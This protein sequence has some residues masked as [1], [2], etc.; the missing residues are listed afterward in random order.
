[1]ILTDIIGIVG[2]LLFLV[3]NIWAGT[4][5]RFIVGLAVGFNSAVVPLYVKEISPKSISGMTGSFN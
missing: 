3:A 2:S 4:A 5:G 1:M